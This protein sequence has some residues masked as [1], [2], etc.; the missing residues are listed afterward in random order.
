M[1]AF[2][3]LLAEA[4]KRRPKV[5]LLVGFSDFNALL[6][7]ALRAQGVRV[8]WYAPPQVWAWRPRR[9]FGL[10]QS[11]DAVATLFPFESSFWHEAGMPVHPVGH[12]ALHDVRADRS[13]ARRALRLKEESLVLGLLPG[14]RP[15]EV[16][17]MLGPFLGALESLGEDA[18]DLEGLLFLAASLPEALR[19]R[20]EGL[21][22]G[23]QRLRL[24]GPE[25]LCA[26]DVALVTS[27]TA[28]LECA[29]AG[30]P[31]VVA[32]RT[33]P[34]SAFLVRSLAQVPRMGLPNL[35]L[36]GPY[37]P[38][39]LQAAVTPRRLADEA[40][41]IV[42]ERPEYQALCGRVRERLGAANAGVHPAATVADLLKDWHHHPHAARGN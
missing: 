5:A 35:V 41:R 25:L 40:R 4:R 8:L 16:E 36:N 15:G 27:G 2:R 37:F 10:R 32:Y 21:A 13:E 29:L 42:R 38:E 17:R 22:R 3:K 7:R 23:R 31:P 14:S 19:R 6:G 11:A 24:A 39:L 26:C 12:P 33:D 20:V 28:T 30:V 18:S 9:R 34:V 1:R